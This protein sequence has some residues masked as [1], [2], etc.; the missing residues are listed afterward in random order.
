MERTGVTI[1]VEGL[2]KHFGKVA[3]VQDLSFTAGPGVITG[4]LGPNGSGKTTT[5]R[6]LLGLVRPTGGE[7][8][9]GGRPYARLADPLRTAGASLEASNFHPARSGRAHLRIQCR[10]A[11]IP[12]SRVDDVLELTGLTD[13]ANR[14]TRGY[15]LGMRQRLN[16]ATALLGDPSVLVLDEP[17]NGL[18]PAGIAWLRGFL[19]RLADEGRTVLVSSHI[20]SEVQQTVDRVVVVYRG[21]GVAEG[22]LGELDP[23]GEG[24]ERVFLRLTSD[25]PAEPAARTSGREDR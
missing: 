18:D 25:T 17:S 2:T 22:T 19:R 3:A 14:A 20:L 21:R 23:E 11:G 9:I 4:F 24:L 16:L 6:C 10:T 12:Q 7:A 15:S 13:A 5:L 8:V 1:R